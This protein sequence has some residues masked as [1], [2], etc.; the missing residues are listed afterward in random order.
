MPH[1]ARSVVLLLILYAILN[2]DFDVLKEP[3]LQTIQIRML[4]NH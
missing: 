3:Y 4:I 1:F 2:F